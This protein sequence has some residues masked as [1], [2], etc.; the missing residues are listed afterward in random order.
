M[1]NIPDDLLDETKSVKEII[2]PEDW[3]TPQE[4]GQLFG[5][6]SRT[7]HRWTE[8]KFKDVMKYKT[9]GGHYRYLK[10]DVERVRKEYEDIASPNGE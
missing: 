4:V 3:L 5:V 1:S 10:T 8:D 6:Q 2:V 9:P 7:V